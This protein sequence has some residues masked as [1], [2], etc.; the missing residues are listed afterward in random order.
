VAGEGEG[1]RRRG[2]QASKTVD[3]L[4]LMRQLPSAVD[5]EIKL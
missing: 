1:R 3:A 5:I 2:E 4:M